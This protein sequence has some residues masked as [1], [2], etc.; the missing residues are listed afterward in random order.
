MNRIPLALGAL[1]VAAQV[2]RVAVLAWTVPELTRGGRP[3]LIEAVQGETVFSQ[4]FDVRSSGL[5]AIRV[6]VAHARE[7]S[8]YARLLGVAS[9]DSEHQLRAH[10]IDVGDEEDC[11]LFRFARIPNSARRRYRVE[12]RVTGAGPSRGPAVLAVA[13]TATGGLRIN[14]HPQP[15]NLV[16]SV[17]GAR[18]APLQGARRLG[19]AGILASFAVADSALLCVLY[20]LFTSSGRRLP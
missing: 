20:W 15:S 5:E 19:L 16:M 8:I 1:F 10:A 18:V 9:D 3:F 12:L 11:C 4:T 6:E 2:A 14:G 13:A 17:D 7:G